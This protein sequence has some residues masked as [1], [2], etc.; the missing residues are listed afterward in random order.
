MP[1]YMVHH[2]H[3]RNECRVAFAAWRG[4]SSPLRSRTTIASCG[5]GG[6]EMWWQVEA[7]SEVEALALLPDW[8]ARRTLI[9][10]IGEVGM[11]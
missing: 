10:R 8:V 5:F 6:H 4:F 11:P 9:A 1:R 3:Q 2:R 7:D